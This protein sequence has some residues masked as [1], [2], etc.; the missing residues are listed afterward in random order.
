MVEQDGFEGLT[1]DVRDDGVGVVLFNR[2]E[3]F[4]A[5]TA[6]TLGI[7][8]RALRTLGDRQDCGAVV[9]SGAGAAFC[10]GMDLNDPGLAEPERDPVQQAYG[11]M[12][13]AVT[14]VLTMR[15][16]PQPVIAAVRGP[17]VGGGFAI[18]AAA[19]IRICSPDVAF[20]A[21][22]VKLG[23]SIGDMGLSWLLPRLIGAGAAAELFYNGGTLGAEES[24]RLG[25]VQHVVDDP[26]QAAVEL[27]AKVASRPRL[28]VQMSKELLNASIA[29]GGLR[30][31]L[32]MEMRSQVIALMTQ[33]HRAAVRAFGSR[34]RDDAK[35]GG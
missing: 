33:D 3:K 29:A 1:V 23:I 9:L 35:P 32:E 31:H 21:P 30:E 27:A 19:D 17:A 4:N 11:A 26:L 25:L 16:I 13:D 28:A 2:S 10:A 18:A 22:F 5:L 34:T 15:E 6:A 12:R 7:L 8:A 20:M 14:C 24:L